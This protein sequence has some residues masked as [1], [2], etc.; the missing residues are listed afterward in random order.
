VIA[1]WAHQMTPT[2][3]VAAAD[4]FPGLGLV[5]YASNIAAVEHL[6]AP[7]IAYL[8]TVA[9]AETVLAWAEAG[10][11]F[12]AVL[13]NDERNAPGPSGSYLTPA[14]YAAQFTPIYDLLR[15]V[16][17][18]FTMGLQ[19]KRGRY[20][21]AYHAQLPP[22]DGRAFNPNKV[23]RREIERALTLADHWILSPAPFRGWWDRLFHQPVSIAG[24]ASIARDPRVTA[25]ALWCLREV[26]WSTGKWQS[27]HGLLDR[28]GRVTR[29]GRE[30]QAALA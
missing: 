30:V 4:R 9:Q 24:W 17:P 23:T 6:K 21:D 12:R 13:V 20:D 2:E 26:Q 11:K 19:P 5:L 3:V 28:F 10:H 14:E 15:G 16:V 7:P 1:A 25:V 29:V 22:A 8:S 18:V 27:E